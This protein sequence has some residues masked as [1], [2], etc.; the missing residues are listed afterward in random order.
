LILLILNAVQTISHCAQKRVTT[1]FFADRC[2]GA[3]SGQNS[4]FVG[5]GEQAGTDGIDDLVEVAARQVSTA[6][7]ARKQSVSGH[8]EIERGEVKAN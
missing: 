8:K 6:D 1:T 5:Q 2:L 4:S 3:M 7:A